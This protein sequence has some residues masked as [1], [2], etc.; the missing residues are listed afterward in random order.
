M[1]INYSSKKART[2]FGKPRNRRSFSISLGTGAS[3]RS[4]FGNKKNGGLLSLFAAHKN[5]SRWN[6]FKK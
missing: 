5:R 1:Q 3:R 2:P 6:I 4:F